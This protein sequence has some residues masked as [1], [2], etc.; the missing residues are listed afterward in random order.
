MVFNIQSFASLYLRLVQ[1]I[2]EV[3]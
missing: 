3:T 1:L 2:A